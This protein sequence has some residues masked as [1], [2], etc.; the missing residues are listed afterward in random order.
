MSFLSCISV[1][2]KQL[3]RATGIFVLI[4]CLYF[5]S[6]ASPKGPYVKDLIPSCCHWKGL[7]ILRG[8][9]CQED[10]RSLR[11]LWNPSFMNN[12]ETTSPLWL[13]CFVPS[14]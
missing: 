9:V 3:S 13:E 2:Y 8:G 4:F 12:K 10:F 7:K 1:P 5:E 6:S 11:G 14:P